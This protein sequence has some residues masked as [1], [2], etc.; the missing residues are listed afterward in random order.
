LTDGDLPGLYRDADSSS[1]DGQGKYLRLTRARLLLVVAASI[2]GLIVL[3]I[4]IHGNEYDAF[5]FFSA[6]FFLAALVAETYLLLSS[7][8]KTWYHGR[9]VAESV[10]TLTWR[11]VMRSDPFQDVPDD[12]GA[13]ALM[14]K[15]L[16]AIISDSTIAADFEIRS[17]DYITPKMRE[18][19]DADFAARKK[20]YL[21]AR[22]D[23]QVRWYRRKARF[24]RNR[25][26]I[27]RAVMLGLEVAGLV[28]AVLLLTKVITTSID[29][30][31]ASMVAAAGAWLEVKQF[32]SLANAYNLTAT[33]LSLAKAD[34]E[35]ITNEAG[36]PQYV[37]TTEDA[38]SREHTMWRVRRIGLR[39]DG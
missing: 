32:E 6:I 10:K 14:M 16:R 15:K 39:L 30:V 29:G 36:W 28:A 2:A 37:A 13:N 18:L 31:V 3:T 33:E 34:G 17:D 19:R 38:I 5:A 1:L 21:V 11:Y 25:A 27:W 4:K 26:N 35:S 12:A 7:P 20:A 8:D 9:A 23:D 22:V 24:N